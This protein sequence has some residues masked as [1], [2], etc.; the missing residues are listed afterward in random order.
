MDGCT[1]CC[2]WF[3]TNAASTAKVAVKTGNIL[4][5]KLRNNL[6]VYRISATAGAKHKKFVTEKLQYCAQ[7]NEKFIEGQDD[8]EWQFSAGNF[9]TV[10]RL[11]SFGRAA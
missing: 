4:V 1:R 7:K 9:A 11:R 10:R 8:T 6:P 2:H 5:C 3:A